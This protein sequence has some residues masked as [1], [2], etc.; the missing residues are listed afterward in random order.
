MIGFIGTYLQLQSI[1]TSSHIEL[2]LKDVRLKNF[3]EE[4]LTE[5]NS[6]MNSL[7][8]LPR[9]PNRSHHVEQLIVLCYSVCCHRN[10][11][12]NI[13]CCVNRYWRNVV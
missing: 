8:Y 9:C 3:Y 13:R 2:L 11:F 6:R 10:I 5:L 4:Y 7:L 1:M 12:V